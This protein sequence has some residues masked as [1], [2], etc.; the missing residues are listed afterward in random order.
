MTFSQTAKKFGWTTGI[1]VLF[2]FAVVA[3]EW[4][5]IP[6]SAVLLIVT[7]L[8]LALA[9]TSEPV[10]VKLIL[11][12]GAA[13]VAAIA[14]FEG[15][16]GIHLW[17]GDGT[18]IEGSVVHDGRL[19]DEILGYVPRKDS[20]LTARKLYGDTVLYD[21]AYSIDSDGLRVSPPHNETEL[22][23]CIVF[24]GDSSTF[25]EGVEDDQPFAYQVGLKTKG[26]Y[27]IYNFAYSGY[28]PHQMLANLLAGRVSN[29]VRCNPT[30]FI[31]F[32]ISE[33]IIPHSPRCGTRSLGQAR[34]S[35][36]I[37]ANRSDT[38]WSF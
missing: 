4:C 31:Y 2:A 38:G 29:I 26:Q 15:L 30:R 32:A 3:V 33:D 9:L 12:N 28:G 7:I 22:T 6:W 11:I 17:R 36:Q 21:V 20:R 13:I 34:A 25:G 19:S 5:P 23:G 37:D 27:A 18:R 1:L 8:M 24:F 16:L 10:A 14:A 35:L